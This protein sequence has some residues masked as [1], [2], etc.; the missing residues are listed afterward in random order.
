MASALISIP[1]VLFPHRSS[2]AR[3]FLLIDVEVPHQPFLNLKDLLETVSLTHVEVCRPNGGICDLQL[4]SGSVLLA[5]LEVGDAGPDFQSIAA[6]VQQLCNNGPKLG[7]LLGASDNVFD[8]FKARNNSTDNLTTF[9]FIRVRSRHASQE[10]Q[11]SSISPVPLSQLQHTANADKAEITKRS[12][13]TPEVNY[14]HKKARVKCN[15]ELQSLGQNVF[16]IKKHNSD[17]TFANSWNKLLIKSCQSFRDIIL[18]S[19]K[20]HR[21]AYYVVSYVYTTNA[22]GRCFKLSLRLA[23]PPEGFRVLVVISNVDAPFCE[24]LDLAFNDPT[25]GN[26]VSPNEVLDAI[27]LDLFRAI[28][29]FYP[30][31]IDKI[32]VCGES[33]AILPEL[34]A[35]INLE[36]VSAEFVP[37]LYVDEARVLLK[38]LVNLSDRRIGR[39]INQRAELQKMLKFAGVGQNGDA[40]RMDLGSLFL[41]RI[42]S[43]LQLYTYSRLP[44]VLPLSNETVRRERVLA[45]IAVRSSREAQ[46]FLGKL[47]LEVV[48]SGHTFKSL[49]PSPWGNVLP[50]TSRL[51]HGVRRS[52]FIVEVAFVPDDT[53]LHLLLEWGIVTEVRTDAGTSKFAVTNE[54][55]RQH[56]LTR[57][58]ATSRRFK[59]SLRS[60]PTDEHEFSLAIRHA[61]ETVYRDIPTR[62]ATTSS[63][64]KLQVLL[65]I[66]LS[67]GFDNSQPKTHCFGEVHARHEGKSKYMDIVLFFDSTVHIL[68]LK[69]VRLRNLFCS[70]HGG[71]GMSPVSKRGS[72]NPTGKQ[73]A[74]FRKRLTQFQLTGWDGT[75]GN[76]YRYNVAELAKLKKRTESRRP[77]KEPLKWHELFYTHISDD[78]SNGE[79]HHVQ[80]LLWDARSQVS[81]Y[82]ELVLSKKVEKG[83]IKSGVTDERIREVGPLN[84]KK[85]K[86]WVIVDL[87]GAKV[88]MKKTLEYDCEIVL[89]GETTG[90]TEHAVY[91]VPDKETKKIYRAIRMRGW[92]SV[93]SQVLYLREKNMKPLLLNLQS[94][95]KPEA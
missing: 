81:N 78:N 94:P 77:S 76:E 90:T 33:T 35:I 3:D 52:P 10:P 21:W 66:L 30:D 54:L 82:G 20:T 60:P 23:Q 41:D 63:E 42:R 61:I 26:Y 93:R 9:L 83:K 6:V 91:L 37:I 67:V 89:G 49:D 17:S 79:L 34:R 36:D 31:L 28:K 74:D 48:G 56:L 45:N 88:L 40:L 70:I 44:C 84:V 57:E 27:R 58:T 13:P 8:H 14:T 12:P 71:L 85:V 46:S 50:W 22:H 53:V 4:G 25:S 16:R 15:I 62:A 68:E 87:G 32:V 38:Q 86:T 80:E 51:A 92:Q 65:E 59:A 1:C 64:A 2:I 7:H 75:D 24:A 72:R 29:P 39:R 69:V 47:A 55:M 18:G 11:A 19:T 43:N 73:L 5:Q 95:L